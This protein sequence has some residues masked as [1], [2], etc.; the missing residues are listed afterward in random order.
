MFI[1]KGAQTNP[2]IPYDQYDIIVSTASDGK[3]SVDG[4]Q[5]NYYYFHAI[6][7]I[8]NGNQP[9]EGDDSLAVIQRFRQNFYETTIE[10][11]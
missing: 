4:L 3:V 10:T 9:V 1:K 5:P 6:A 11:H 8:G 7:F 2:H